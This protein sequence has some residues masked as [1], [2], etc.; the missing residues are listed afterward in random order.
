MYAQLG[1][2]YRAKVRSVLN[3]KNIQHNTTTQTTSL[4]QALRTTAKM[5]ADNESMKWLEYLYTQNEINIV[6]LLAWIQLIADKQINR[7]NTLVLQ[8]PT[9]SGK[10]LTLNTIFSNL[11]TTLLTRNGDQ[12][13]FYFQNLLNKTYGLF[14]EPRISNVTVDDYKLLFEGAPLEVNVKHSDP[15]KLDRTP[16]FIS[17]NKPIDYWVPPQD[18]AALYARTK[19]FTFTKEIKVLSDRIQNQFMLDAP[20]KQITAADFLGLYEKYR[21]EIQTYITSIQNEHSTSNT[22]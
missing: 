17:T 13:Q 19:T 18:G 1:S 16:I 22:T 12:N 10:S 14:E 20:P 8:G 15:E 7:V 9:G 21:Q 3:Y 2:A 11:N 6:H 4:I 5:P